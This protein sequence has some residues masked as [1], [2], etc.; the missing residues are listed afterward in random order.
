[1]IRNKLLDSLDHGGG[2]GWCLIP[3]TIVARRDLSLMEKYLLG[4][5]VG[6]IGSKGYCY[7]SNAW[8]G[9]QL[10]AAKGTVANLLSKLG[11]RHLIRIEVIY[12]SRGEVEER[13]IYPSPA[14]LWEGGYSLQETDLRLDQGIPL[15]HPVKAPLHRTVKVEGRES[16]VEMSRTA[17]ETGSPADPGGS[18]SG[19]PSHPGRSAGSLPYLPRNFPV[20]HPVCRVLSRFADRWA[21][22]SGEVLDVSIARAIKE[23]Q[24]RLKTTPLDDLLRLVD[25]WFD[26]GLSWVSLAERGAFHTFIQPR[27]VSELK[28]IKAGLST[29][30]AGRR[31]RAGYIKPLTHDEWA[32]IPSGQ[33]NFSQGRVVYHDNAP[34]GPAAGDGVNPD[35]L[36]ANTWH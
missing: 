28:G 13:R 29:A 2:I 12:S 25:L 36:E 20:D 24:L 3:P 21:A 5:I 19:G 30:P 22:M 11:K 27:A 17:G 7:A 10:G 33:L 14:L 15:H 32:D 31:E 6:L 23:I 26:P 9:A 16:R 1:V 18:S 35:A 8:L 4:R 34:D